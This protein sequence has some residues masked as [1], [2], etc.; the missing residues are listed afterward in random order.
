MPK[1]NQ[2]KDS[3]GFREDLLNLLGKN[4]RKTERPQCETDYTVDQ[5]IGQTTL[6]MNCEGCP[7]GSCLSDPACRE[8]VVCKLVENPVDRVEFARRLTTEEYEKD[9]VELLM[10]IAAL[11]VDIQGS[12]FGVFNAG[13][14]EC[15]A[16]VNALKDAI[17]E[18][19]QRDAIGAAKGMDSPVDKEVVHV[20][21]ECIKCTNL[22]N[23]TLTYIKKRIQGTKLVARHPR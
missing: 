5:T 18:S 9:D 14:G 12:P 4:S 3:D 6:R 21:T 22:R 13:C 2:K 23:S 17:V 15:E 8:M 7:H 19:L 10:E 1:E 16:K 20:K 11:S